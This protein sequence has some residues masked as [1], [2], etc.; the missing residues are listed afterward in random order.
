MLKVK[1]LHCGDLHLDTPFTSIAYEQGR[2]EQLR[3]ELKQAFARIVKLAVSENVDM[4]LICGDLYEHGYTRK[5][6]IS[7]VCDQLRLISHIPVLIIPG[8]HDPAVAGSFYCSFDW[9]DNVHILYG[10]NYIFQHPDTKAYVYGY[11]SQEQF[12]AGKNILRDLER[13][14]ILMHHGTL[15]MPFSTE[16]YNPIT[17][18]ELDEYGFDYCAMGHFHT[19][20]EKAGSKK[21]IYNP[22]SPEP[23][24]FDEEGEHGIFITLI[25]KHPG[26]KSDVRADF[27]ALNKRNFMNIEV[28]VEGCLN[29]EQAAE[30]ATAAIKDTGA[31]GD[32]YRIKLK[33]YIARDFKID[34]DYIAGLLES[35][36]FYIRI[37]DC[38]MPDYDFSQIAGEP[39]L[40]GLFTR[41]ML[42]KASLAKTEQERRL[43]MQ[44]LYYGME[45]IDEGK[46]CI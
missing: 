12:L 7:Y 34:T 3:N 31:A 5:S 24:G 44:A 35:E 8:N 10:D 14:N 33:G 13:I 45:A 41:K 36:A 23:L 43:V 28:N 37:E 22:G 17:S 32:L 29:D 11:I 6:T 39:G 46:V 4:V 25:E 27:I 16:A 38:T 1:L 21:S 30:R 42:K 18:A 2:P 15:D 20:F 26:E 19:R 40:R 9:P